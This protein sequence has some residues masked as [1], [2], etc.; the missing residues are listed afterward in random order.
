MGRADGLYPFLFVGIKRVNAV[1]FATLT[2]G[3]FLLSRQPG[4]F[5]YR[6]RNVMKG[7]WIY[8]ALTAVIVTHIVF[9]ASEQA[10]FIKKYLDCKRAIERGT[11]SAGFFLCTPQQ[12]YCSSLVANRFGVGIYSS[13]P[14]EEVGT[15]RAIFNGQY[16]RVRTFWETIP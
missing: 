5:G 7:S 9:I 2:L 11:L 10:A 16:L 1:G 4:T 6:W 12:P 13:V 15:H 14:N 3:R 8:A